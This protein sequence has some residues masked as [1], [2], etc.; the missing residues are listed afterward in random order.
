MSYKSLSKKAKEAVTKVKD[1][2]DT[3]PNGVDVDDIAEETGLSL[4]TVEN[5]LDLMQGIVRKGDT[6]SLAGKIEVKDKGYKQKTTPS[7]IHDDTSEQPV[8]PEQSLYES[9]T[10]PKSPVLPVRNPITAQDTNDL[11]DAES[12]VLPVR[13]PIATQD[14]NDL[15]DADTSEQVAIS[16]VPDLNEQSFDTNEVAAPT[17]SNAEHPQADNMETV[18]APAP[19]LATLGENLDEDTTLNEDA[20]EAVSDANEDAEEAVSDAN[21]DVTEAAVETTTPTSNSKTL[22]SI[23]TDDEVIYK[24]ADLAAQLKRNKSNPYTPIGV[25]GFR[26]SSDKSKVTL[27]LSRRPSSASLTL[28][29]EQI[30]AIQKMLE[31][32]KKRAL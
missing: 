26:V 19:I 31:E 12:P 9:Y 15:A 1:I 14:T 4:I 10:P 28:P 7:S 18:A 29:V 2:L 6:I 21:E 16:P 17:N 11:A 22:K 8:K 25:D 27:F 5:T 3:H 13:N 30:D 20:E 32:A 23:K 24:K